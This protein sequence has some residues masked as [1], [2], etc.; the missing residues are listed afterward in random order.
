MNQ[1]DKTLLNPEDLETVT[2]GK[3]IRRSD[4]VD[5]PIE[6]AVRLRCRNCGEVFSADSRAFFVRCPA[7][8]AM[9]K[10]NTLPLQ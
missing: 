9:V 2:G 1:E 7:C 4:A 5:D 6:D 10:V 3:Q 8:H